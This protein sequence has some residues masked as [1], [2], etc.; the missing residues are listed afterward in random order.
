MFIPVVGDKQ[1]M[2]FEHRS[3]CQRHPGDILC[4]ALI[5]SRLLSIAVKWPPYCTAICTSP[6]TGPS[7]SPSNG[8][9]DRNTT[10]T[11]LRPATRTWLHKCTRLK[12][13]SCV[14]WLCKGR[15]GMQRACRRSSTNHRTD[16]R[17]TST[18]FEATSGLF[19]AQCNSCKNYYH[20][21][22]EGIP[23]TARLEE[24]SVDLFFV[25]AIIPLFSISFRNW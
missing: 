15:H 5:S 22:C 1:R 19:M 3:K 11:N 7:S 25:Y 21:Q 4:V 16:E 13:N 10:E 17:E 14:P 9:E 6:A 12:S 23:Q 24:N 2:G 8:R 20:Q 18:R